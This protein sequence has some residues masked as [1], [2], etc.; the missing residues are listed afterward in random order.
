MKHRG[1]D[2]VVTLVR[3]N[4]NCASIFYPCQDSERLDARFFLALLQNDLKIKGVYHLLE[5]D[6]GSTSGWI[7][8]LGDAL[9]TMNLVRGKETS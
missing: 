4:S 3:E 1:I 2:G 7:V 8:E 6:A 5:S 9:A